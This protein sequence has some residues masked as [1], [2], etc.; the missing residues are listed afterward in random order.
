[1]KKRSL[2]LRFSPVSKAF[3]VRNPRAPVLH[4]DDAAFPEAMLFQQMPH[5]GIV[6]VGVNADVGN[7]C[8][9]VGQAFPEDSFSCTASGNPVDG[10]VGGIIQPLALSD[11][12]VGGVFSYNEGEDPGYLSLF[13]QH[14]ALSV[15]DIIQQCFPGGPAVAPLAGVSGPAHLFSCICV[16][17][18]NPAVVGGGSVAYGHLSDVL[19]GSP[20]ANYVAESGCLQPFSSMP[21]KSLKD[22]QMSQSGRSGEPGCRFP[23]ERIK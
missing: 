17:F 20:A 16:D 12:S 19:S 22:W 10:A 9:A 18:L 6:P 5:E 2:T 3:L 23:D 21:A 11:D 13:F 14:M 15:P 1:M 8:H 7:L 4:I